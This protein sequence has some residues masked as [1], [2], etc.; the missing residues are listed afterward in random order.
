M[1]PRRR[2][3]TPRIPK[4]RKLKG[5]QLKP[6]NGST[7]YAPVC[8]EHFRT[9]FDN[10]NLTFLKDIEDAL[11][12]HDEITLSFR[13]TENIK[14]PALLVIYSIIDTVG[15]G[16]KVN[17]IFSDRSEQVNENLK[18]S[19]LFQSAEH[20][21]KML[22]E[23]KLPII[24]GSNAVVIPLSRRI[25]KSIVELHL[26]EGEDEFAD[27]KAEIGVAINET[28]ENVGRHAYPK[29]YEHHMKEWWFCCNLIDGTLFMAI[30]DKG[31]GIPYRIKNSDIEFTMLM[32]SYMAITGTDITKLSPTVTANK[33]DFTRTYAD[34]VLIGAAM[35]DN[36]S[37]TTK[38]KH[39][40]GSGRMK[41]LIKEKESSFMIIGSGKGM[42]TY[43]KYDENQE[44]VIPLLNPIQGTLIQWSL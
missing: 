19:G 18:S 10:L 11:I 36:L 22:D 13:Y 40:K 42:Y 8:V 34:E 5:L 39:G 7:I 30:Y 4:K 35:S 43:S 28:L 15:K 37:T 6:K 26:D 17:V 44:K 29:E 21:L 2:G 25:V 1:A 16:K 38:K 41:A 3:L 20:R 12:K 23:N 33:Y 24:K 32:E 9:G 31:V 27:R 14:A